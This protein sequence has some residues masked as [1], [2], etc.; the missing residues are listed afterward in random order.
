LKMTPFK[1][2][3]TFDVFLSAETTRTARWYAFYI[4]NRYI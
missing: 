2:A 1:I 4:R 3:F